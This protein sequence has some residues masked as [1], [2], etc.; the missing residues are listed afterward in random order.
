MCVR[1]AMLPSWRSSPV[2]A[3]RGTPLS[4]APFFLFSFLPSFLSSGASWV[5]ARCDAPSLIYMHN[6][7]GPPRIVSEAQQ[8]VPAVD[9]W[10]RSDCVLRQLQPFPLAV[11]A[12]N[13]QSWK[14]E[15]V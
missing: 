6:T 11:V 9:F 7:P 3:C 8:V 4:T 10:L 1:R 2:P 15:R 5:L 12:A 14:D 13:R